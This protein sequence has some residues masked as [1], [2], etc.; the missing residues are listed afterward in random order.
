MRLSDR[1]PRTGVSL[2]TV[3]ACFTCT[4]VITFALTHGVSTRAVADDDVS[5]IERDAMSVYFTGVVKH[6]QLLQLARTGKGRL[7]VVGLGKNEV[8]TCEDLGLQLRQLQRVMNPND[9]FVIATDSAGMGAVRRFLQDE[10]VTADVVAIGRLQDEAFQFDGRPPG[11]P[12]AALIGRD[13]HVRQGV[14]HSRRVSGV[15]PRSFVAEL[16][17]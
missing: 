5:V 4:V 9:H 11:L 15:R 13:G 12:F 10:R 2:I 8:I 7:V 17:L 3:V 1:I 16:N 6:P 14:A